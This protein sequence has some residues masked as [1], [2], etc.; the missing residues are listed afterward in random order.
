MVKAF[1]ESEEMKK[2]TTN[3][4]ELHERRNQSPVFSTFQ[5]ARNWKIS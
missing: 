2:L 1:P 4:F 5:F 3:V